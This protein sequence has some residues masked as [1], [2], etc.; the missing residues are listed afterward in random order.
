M[1]AA[2]A[3]Q[4]VQHSSQQTTAPKADLRWLAR[5][6]SAHRGAALG[7]ILAGVIGG[8]GTA[9]QPYLIGHIIDDLR[10]GVPVET[11]GGEVLLFL[12]LMIVIL[13]AFFDQRQWSGTVVY[14]VTYD[15][16]RA[17]FQHMLTLDQGFYQRYATGDLIA[18]LNGDVDMIW[19]LLALFFL[20]IGSA[21]VILIGAF[22]LLGTISL[23]L[24]LV[25]FVVLAIS[26]TFQIR[27]GRVLTPVFERVQDQAG[28]ISAYVQD[29]VSGIQTIK[30]FGREAD[31]ARRFHAE[32]ME[33]RRRWLHFKRR[34]EPVGMLPNAISETTAGIVVVFGGILTVNGG[35][36]LGNFAQFLIYL[37]YISNVLLQ[38]GTL[39]QRYQQ[40]RGALLRITPLLQAPAISDP[41]NARPLPAPRGEIRLE[42]VTLEVGGQ[43]LLRDISLHIPAGQTVAVVGPTGCGKTLLINLLARIFDP[44]AGRVLIDG[45]DVRHV[46][47]DE[48]RRAIAY[49]PQTT[50]LFSQPL[51]RNVRMA[52]EIDDDMLMQAINISRISN[53]LPQLPQGI[54]TLV[55]ERGV[56]LSGG[57]KQRV[58]IARA[59][60]HDP[61]ILVLDD[62]L[63]SVDT[64]TAADILGNLREVL[65]AR[66]SIIIAHRI[67]TIKDADVIYV[68]DEGRIVE[69]GTHQELIANGN[70]Y[71]RMVEREDMRELESAEANHG[72]RAE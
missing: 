45:V 25:V 62:A 48:L 11:L 72:E 64:H 28:A 52:H 5:F 68:M 59:I 10:R 53:D 14:S 65:R 2:N 42:N 60:V 18:R 38:L 12:A 51:H 1:Q 44:T 50:F 26:T 22:L 20:R 30:T 39:Y 15:I 70:L 63:S 55:G 66:T 24:T 46:R 56:M 17:L 47:L 9:L 54:E 13:V 16:R 7:S 6:V 33:F 71:A 49:V 19:R 31:A 8:I 34:N 41:P 58:A 35:M 69:H 36:T 37:A 3:A 43:T 4:A 21:T 27:A 32:N 61:A 23:P 29:T 67:A 40:T 57:Q